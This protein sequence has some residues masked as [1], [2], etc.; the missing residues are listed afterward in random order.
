MPQGVFKYMLPHSSSNS[1]D[2]VYFPYWRFKGMIFSCLGTGTKSKFLDVSQ[3]AISSSYFPVS[4]GLRSQAMTLK[5]V[6]P[7]SE[8][9]FLRPEISLEDMI[10]VLKKRFSADLPKPILYQAEIGE[11]ISLIYSPFYVKEKI[12]DAILNQPVSSQLP[13][14][15][16]LTS[17]PTDKRPIGVKF[18]PTLCP[19]C[20]WDLSGDKDSLS[21]LC[22]NC[23]TLWKPSKQGLKKLTSA[24]L[25]SDE[26]TLLYL[27]FWRI[28]AE[29]SDISLTSYADFVRL[30]NLP[31]VI[32]DGWEKIGFR[33]WQPAFKVRPQS[34]LRVAGAVTLNQPTDKL[35]PGIPTKARLHQVN[36]PLSEA[37]ESLK[38]TLADF[39]RPKNLV[40][41]ILEQMDIQAKS[42]LLVYLPFV[43]KHHEFVQTR[44]NL[45]VNKNQLALAKNL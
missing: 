23:D 14:D 42:F 7:D 31:K 27:P 4:V 21:L 3:Q 6:T 24:F 9:I 41:E 34:Y 20:G 5:F 15:F 10:G 40:I 8:G 26:E 38:L 35:T 2:V 44:M 33:F 18:L 37:I 17:F 36:L 19:E 11:T 32:Q 16:N 13:E 1:G 28:K 25:A 30:A 29:V 45:A 39:M 43:E 22:K 12:V